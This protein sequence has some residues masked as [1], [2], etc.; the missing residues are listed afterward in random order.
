MTSLLDPDLYPAAEI[1]ELYQERWELE[2]GFDEIKTHTF[3]RAET[4]RSKAPD[5]ILQEI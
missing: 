2:L 5:R 4:L 3:E 1:V